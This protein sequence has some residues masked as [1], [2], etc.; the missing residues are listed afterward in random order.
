MS[1]Y[2]LRRFS[3]PERDDFCSTDRLIE[4]ILKAINKVVLEPSVDS[5]Y[6]S[7]TLL[8]S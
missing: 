1:P 7:M 6:N 5:R 3:A 2:K 4:L 8:G